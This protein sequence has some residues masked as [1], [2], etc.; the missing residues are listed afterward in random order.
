MKTKYLF[1][2]V[3]ALGMAACAEVDDFSQNYAPAGG[4]VEKGYLAVDLNADGA[5]RAA[6]DSY[7][8]GTTAEQA[9]SRAAFFFFDADGKAYD[10][11][12]NGK[13]RLDKNYSNS[14][15]QEFT[16]NVNVE[17]ISDPILVIKESKK[18]P[19]QKIVAVLNCPIDN[20]NISL[21]SKVK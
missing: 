3:A 8:D 14:E 15:D 12:G 1:L 4:G 6:G 16:G 7:E 13:N 17:E 9:V 18:V 21:L 19:P 2:A 10:V 5:T 11:T 20:D